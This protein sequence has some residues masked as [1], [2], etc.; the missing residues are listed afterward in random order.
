V[1]RLNTKSHDF[2]KLRARLAAELLGE[3]RSGYRED[4]AA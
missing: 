2:L 3:I 4:S 1:F